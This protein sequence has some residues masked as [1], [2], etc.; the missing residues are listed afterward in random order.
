METMADS[1][2]NISNRRR[3]RSNSKCAKL[4]FCFNSCF[5]SSSSSSSSSMKISRSILSPARHKDHPFSL[6][7]S[8]TRRLTSNG[9]IKGAQSP[10]YPTATAAAATSKKRGGATLDNP[11]PSSP[12]V[13][14][15]GQVRVK[16][17]K[18]KHGRKLRTPSRRRSGGADGSFRRSD[19][20]GS[21]DLN[22]KQA[23]FTENR[24]RTQRWVHLPL[25]ICQGL[26]GSC[27]FSSSSSRERESKREKSMRS[28]LEVEEQEEIEIGREKFDQDVEEVV[29]EEEDDEEGE[30][31]LSFSVPPKN[32]LLLMRCRSDPMRVAALSRRLLESPLLPDGMNLEG[33]EEESDP[34]DDVGG[35]GGEGEINEE[36]EAVTMVED[37]EKQRET[38]QFDE[39]D[40]IMDGQKEEEHQEEEVDSEKISSTMAEDEDEEEEEKEVY[41]DSSLSAAAAVASEEEEARESASSVRSDSESNEDLEKESTKEIETV[42][43]KATGER[44]VGS[45][46]EEEE[47]ETLDRENETGDGAM[48]VL[49]DCLLLMMREP[50]VSMEVSKETW[51]CSTDFKRILP[52]RRR[53]A[54][55]KTLPAGDEDPTT[56]NTKR[57]D[58]ALSLSSSSSSRAPKPAAVKQRQQTQQQ[59]AGR[60]SCSLP[61]PISTAEKLP[62]C[63][64]EPRTAAA[65]LMAAAPSSET[66]MWKSRKVEQLRRSTAEVVG[67]AAGVGF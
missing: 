46:D 14:C 39:D 64:S 42:K 44:I 2:N 15:I 63:K 35:G 4:F 16:S 33:G 18:K 59:Q 30:G 22:C 67:P 40:S 41:A 52:E 26:K 55:N 23:S 48:S 47:K 29:Q 60:S 37:E 25:T 10:F 21:A 7:S 13:T 3:R 11:E 45:E 66:C 38:E 31:R 56:K 43:V 12:K 57:V 17:K 6:S 27:C 32:A 28:D 50:K 49:P 65:K 54:T 51:V 9:S 19:N 58:G 5:F 53:P 36:S 1:D 62:R 20:W 8:L 34:V 61:G 24:H